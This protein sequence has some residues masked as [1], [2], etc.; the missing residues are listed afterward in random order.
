V[1]RTARRDVIRLLIEK[2]VPYTEVEADALVAQAKRM[3]AESGR[4]VRAEAELLLSADRET[5]LLELRKKVVGASEL[6][7]AVGVEVEELQAESDDDHEELAAIMAT[8]AAACQP[9]TAARAGGSTSTTEAG[10]P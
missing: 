3:A 1:A 6:L 4:A 7:A 5:R 10:E 9:F 2:Q 8:M